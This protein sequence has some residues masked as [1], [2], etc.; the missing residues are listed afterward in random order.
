V[1]EAAG[2]VRLGLTGKRPGVGVEGVG[3][4]QVARSRVRIRVRKVNFF[5]KSLFIGQELEQN[6]L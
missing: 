3:A 4:A 6:H 1:A 2:R 5:I